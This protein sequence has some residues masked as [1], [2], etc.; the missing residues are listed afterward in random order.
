MTWKL[1]EMWNAGLFF[2]RADI[3]DGIDLLKRKKAQGVD[4]IPGSVVKDLKDVISMPLTWLFNTI[5]ESGKIP[6]AWKA[7]RIVPVFKKGD[8]KLIMNYRPVSN[9]SALSKIFEKCLI[10]RIER[11]YGYDSLMGEHQHAY[12]PGCS[13]VTA[14]LTLQDFIASEIDKGNKVAVYSTDLTAAFDL[15][16]PSLLVKKLCDLN[17]PRSYINVIVDFLSNRTGFVDINGTYSFI[18]PIPLGCVQGSVLGPFLF[19]IYTSDL[20]KV[21]KN[22]EHSSHVTVYADDA[23]VALPFDS[24]K[25]PW[26]SEVTERVFL[27]HITWLKAIGMICNY[28]KTDITIFGFNGPGLRISLGGTMVMTKDT[29]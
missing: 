15:L 11:I 3:C 25:F 28:A 24:I 17:L 5:I 9:T 6:T 16:R 10:K 4:E 19:N 1:G 26:C 23:Y 2:C 27:E 20:E 21:I 7:S 22:V 18:K 8:K 12:R 14:A 29:I 13:T